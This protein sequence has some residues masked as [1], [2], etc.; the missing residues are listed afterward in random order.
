MT[1]IASRR[2]IGSIKH[3]REKNTIQMSKQ[4]LLYIQYGLSK[5]MAHGSNRCDE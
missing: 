2:P 1:T 5:P 4:E 3:F